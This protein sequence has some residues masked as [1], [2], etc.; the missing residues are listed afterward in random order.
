[1]L[2][3]SRLTKVEDEA[4][5][6]TYHW[7]TLFVILLL[8]VSGCSSQQKNAD[9]DF[10]M[11]TNDPFQDPFF[12]DSAQEWDSS[13]LKQS[14]VLAQDVPKDPDEPMT[15]IEKS[16][17]ALMGAVMVGGGVAKLL[18]LPFLGL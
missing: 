16:E 6:K 17:S 13:V 15:W 10:L 8:C 4:E 7:K 14:E 9:D 12:T 18:F 5:M 2:R 1:M 11:G 3:C